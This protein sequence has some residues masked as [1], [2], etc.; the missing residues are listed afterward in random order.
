MSELKTTN[1]KLT[2]KNILTLC[3]ACFLL[4]LSQSAPGQM[5]SQMDR[6]QLQ[7]QRQHHIRQQQRY[8]N[9]LQQ[10]NKQQDRIKRE[11]QQMQLQLK[12]NQIVPQQQQEQ[13]EK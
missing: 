7:Y 2:I 13:Q 5:N 6:L 4:V 12:R 1:L 9:Q 11:N 3:S 8:D 10:F